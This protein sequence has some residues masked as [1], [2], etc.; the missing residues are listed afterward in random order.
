MPERFDEAK[1]A[2]EGVPARDVWDEAARRAASGAN[3]VPLTPPTVRERRPGRWLAAA[4]A[5]VLVVGT[6]AVVASDDEAPVDTG[7]SDTGVG[8]EH[9]EVYQAEEACPIGIR[10]EPRLPDPALA[11]AEAGEAGA[12]VVSGDL[13]PTQDY[14]V[15]AP[16][17]VVRDFAGDRVED[18]Q[19]RRGTAQLWYHE[20]PAT[21]GRSGRAAQV[22]WFQ[23]TQGSCD[24]FS[25]TVV[26]GTD[27]ENRHAAVELAERV[28][29]ER[30]LPQAA[31][32]AEDNPLAG[33]EW[34]LEQTALAGEVTDT[35]EVLVFTFTET[36]ASWDDGCNRFDGTYA[37]EDD[38][39][40]LGEVELAHT[41]VACE[42]NPT[43]EAVDAVMA[44]AATVTLDGARLVLRS[45][46]AQ[47][48]LW[49][50]GRT[51][52]VPPDGYG[53]W[54]VTAPESVVGYAPE[55]TGSHRDVAL[56]FADRVLGWADAEITDAEPS[57]DGSDGSVL[58]V[59][60][61]L[62][63]GQVEVRVRTGDAP[64]RSVVY[65]FDTPERLADPD[66]T[67]SVQ[68]I[69]STAS[70]HASPIPDG[71]DAIVRFVYGERVAEGP[72]SDA[73]TIDRDPDVPGAVLVLFVDPARDVV[74]GGWGTT[75]PAGDFAA[76]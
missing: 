52:R 10:G 27:D 26:G 35:D 12:T 64:D 22:R 57:E 9:V 58:L 34:F 42:S 25:I 56:A 4:A 70:A 20:R 45:G 76:G 44:D 14:V 3:L 1:R 8:S 19:L 62:A 59:S 36:D 18:V 53:I 40:D 55:V 47:L 54:P 73:L 41:H 30:E 2:L 13:N 39:L 46:D 28:V 38:R 69:G 17:Q 16:A 6:V 7:G 48:I 75:L 74:V 5:L 11:P 61:E 71:A 63:R 15:Q 29:L 51:V 68:V 67:A 50:A 21:D 31:P 43:I 49:Q 32:P 66:S 24:S 37:Y 72:A 60:S 33:T 65:G 23:D